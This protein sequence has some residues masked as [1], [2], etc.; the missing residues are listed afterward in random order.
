MKV[1]QVMEVKVAVKVLQVMVVL[2]VKVMVKV[3]QVMEVKKE[4][5]VAVKVKV[6]E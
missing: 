5:E 1:F 6:K 4:T 3:F 2:S